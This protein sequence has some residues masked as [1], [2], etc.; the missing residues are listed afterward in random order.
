M[1]GDT[2]A[3][4]SPRPT[5]VGVG[6][7]DDPLLQGL[8]ADGKQRGTTALALGTHNMHAPLVVFGGATAARNG[9]DDLEL[10]AVLFDQAA[11]VDVPVQAR[12]GVVSVV[13]EILISGRWVRGCARLSRVHSALRFCGPCLGRVLAAPGLLT[14]STAVLSH[15]RIEKS[16]HPG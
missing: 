5:H 6:L 9:L 11:D 1:E 16:I 3:E 15:V 2:S 14:L 7:S 12:V 10:F 4:S 8:L 13:V